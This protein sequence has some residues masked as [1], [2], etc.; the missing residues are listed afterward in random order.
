MLNSLQP[1]KFWSAKGL[2][3]LITSN[4]RNILQRFSVNCYAQARC[5]RE[6][7]L[8]SVSVNGKN[9]KFIKAFRHPQVSTAPCTQLSLANEKRVDGSLCSLNAHAAITYNFIFVF[10][11]DA[12]QMG[13][14]FS[15]TL[16][17]SPSFAFGFVDSNF[18]YC[19]TECTGKQRA[20]KAKVVPMD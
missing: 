16:A 11:F 8:W 9:D 2:A 13:Q 10:H 12:S 4:T 6:K 19:V 15:L 3:I 17:I 18:C 20:S 5:L 1:E 7:P 14:T